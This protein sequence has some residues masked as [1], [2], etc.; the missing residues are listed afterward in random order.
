MLNSLHM[1]MS[2]FDPDAL[3]AGK[4]YALVC[5]SGRRS[6]AIAER[7]ESEQVK[8]LPGGIATLRR[9]GLA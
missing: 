1:P 9:R 5:R 3:E 7:I 2:G 6:L 8:S 4:R